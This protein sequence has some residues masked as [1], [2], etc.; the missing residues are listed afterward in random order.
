MIERINFQCVDCG[1][2]MTTEEEITCRQCGRV[3]ALRNSIFLA[4]PTKLATLSKEEAEYHDTP[5]EDAKN[6]HQLESW[7][8]LFYHRYIRSR[9]QSVFAGG[10]VL[11]VGAGTGFDA[12]ELAGKC[13]LV[14]SDISAGILERTAA[15]LRQPNSIYI[16]ADGIALPFANETFDGAFMVA[17]LHHFEQPERA[18]R[19]MYRVLK[20]GGVAVIGIEPNAFYFRTVK[21]LR[22]LLC[23][24]THAD[25][26]AGSHADAEMTGFTYGDLQRLFPHSEWTDRNIKPMWLFS[27]FLHYGLEFLF[28]ALRLKRRI[29]APILFEKIIVATDE[30]LLRLPGVKH[31]GWHWIVS[32][33]KI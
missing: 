9:I 30:L 7:R 8:N 11:E 1:G 10:T 25:P 22:K 23:K 31:I 26:H 18:V 12:K 28:R 15:A 4:Q 14:L 19:E 16:A 29:L 2:A 20:I 3:Y 13:Q 33:K 17:T 32:A 24:L 21:R 5:A 27:G 6:V